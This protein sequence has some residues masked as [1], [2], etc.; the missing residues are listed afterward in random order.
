MDLIRPVVRHF[1]FDYFLR[2]DGYRISQDAAELDRSQYLPASALAERQLKKLTALLSYCAENNAFYRQRF[3]QIGLLPAALK[4]L[5]EFRNVPVLTKDDIRATG[6]ALFSQGYSQQN[7]VHHRTGGSTGVPLHTYMDVPAMSF[8]KAAT[9]RH[10]GWAHLVPGDRLAAVWGD[11][12]KPHPFKAR[13]RNA[14][15]DRAFY[16]DTLHFDE[17]HLRRFVSQIRRYRPAVL[18][19]HAHS[20]YRLADY[21]RAHAIEDVAFSSIITTAMAVACFLLMDTRE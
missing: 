12:D 6:E 19:G 14:L 17:S 18:L 8:K 2:R 7:T 20:I 11:T 3:R 15:T 1:T 13:L 16:L 10:N 4:S 21:V 9:L 5:E